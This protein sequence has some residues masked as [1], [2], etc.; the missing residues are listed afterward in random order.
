MVYFLI[1]YWIFSALVTFP[2]S[3]REFNIIVSIVVCIFLGWIAFP[4][5]L[6]ATIS[7][8]LK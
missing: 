5:Q 2:I 4:I 1:F 8:I 3:I 6:G 7:E